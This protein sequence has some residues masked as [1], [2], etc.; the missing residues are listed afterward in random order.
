MRRRIGQRDRQD[1]AQLGL[2]IEMSTTE[3]S[4]NLFLFWTRLREREREGVDEGKE[5]DR[6]SEQASEYLVK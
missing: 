1:C 3:T 5:M 6:V 4:W 2:K